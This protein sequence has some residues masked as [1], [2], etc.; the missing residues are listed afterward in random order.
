MV[1]TA[2]AMKVAAATEVATEVDMEL[3]REVVVRRNLNVKPLKEEG[4]RLGVEA[5]EDG[6][7]VNV[8]DFVNV[9]DVNSDVNIDNSNP[10]FQLP[11][12]PT[13]VGNQPVGGRLSL[14]IDNWKQVTKDPWILNVVENGYS[15]DFWTAPPL[16]RE[17][18]GSALPADREKEVCH[19]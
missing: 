4:V 7:V 11:A 17:P 18:R 15:V 2:A 5:R 14:Y 9:E 3:D 13:T 8:E 12:F 1:A 10:N 6:N 19:F 16:T